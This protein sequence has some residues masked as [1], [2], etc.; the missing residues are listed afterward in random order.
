M[1]KDLLP[2][3][4]NLGVALVVAVVSSVLTVRLALRRFYSEKLWERKSAAYTMIIEA[5][6]HVREYTDTNLQFSYRGK[7]L[8]E[9]GDKALTENLRRAMA[10][11][12]KQRDIGSFVISEDAT[13]CLNRLFSELDRST[14]THDWTEHLEMKLAAVD[15]C[16]GEMRRMAYEDLS[17]GGYARQ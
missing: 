8:P 14:Q 1:L 13:A 11:L 7:E 17:L 2:I 16:L 15:G 6:H 4:G 5:L 9:D 12:R 10:D 3:L